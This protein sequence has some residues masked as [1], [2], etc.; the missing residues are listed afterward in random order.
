MGD[1]VD[2]FVEDSAHLFL[3]RA[4]VLRIA[5]EEGRSVRVTA[6]SALGG[7]G[8]VLAELA[9]YQRAAVGIPDLL[10]VAIDAN[11]SGW[12][13]ARAT[14]DCAIDRRRFPAVAVAV[15]DPHIERWYMADPAALARDLGV[16]VTPGR[17]KC[18][19]G[20]YKRLLSAGFRAADL[21]V[22]TG[23]FDYAEDIVSGMDLYAAGRNEPSLKHFVD[24]VRAALRGL[25]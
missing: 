15:P 21:P 8:R 3:V 4:L 23:E 9:L 20:H 22:L 24:E 25:G 11:C 5:G 13:G 7:H 16:R 10:V 17:L 18:E 14:I 12:N 6:R 19:R 2:L 1:R